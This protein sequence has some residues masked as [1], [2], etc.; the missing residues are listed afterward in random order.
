[1][2]ISR[3][4]DADQLGSW[5]SIVTLAG[6]IALQSIK[7]RAGNAGLLLSWAVVTAP[8]VVAWCLKPARPPYGEA[9]WLGGLLG[10][11]VLTTG[12][13]TFWRG[14]PLDTIDRAGPAGRTSRPHRGR[15]RAGLADSAGTPGSR[16][17]GDRRRP[18]M[19]G[20][21]VGFADSLAG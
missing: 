13:L 7:V 9:F 17:G 8:A 19:R 14:A 20:D 21:V 4:P 16:R 2:P 18:R 12:I 1:A 15:A 10:R 6:L 3:P 5:L 11:L